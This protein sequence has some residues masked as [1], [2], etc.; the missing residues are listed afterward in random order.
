[1]AQGLTKTQ[2]ADTLVIGPRSVE[3]HLAAIY[4][5]LEVNTRTAAARYASDR[6]LG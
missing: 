1:M 2:A 5:K 6:D 3:K 4:R